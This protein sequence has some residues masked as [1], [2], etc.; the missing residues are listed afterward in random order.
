MTYTIGSTLYLLQNAGDGFTMFSN[1]KL[2]VGS[3]YV[4]P[5]DAEILIEYFKNQLNGNI[6]SQK[7]GQKEGRINILQ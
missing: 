1:C 7:Y 3:S 6:T 2:R 4:F 5:T